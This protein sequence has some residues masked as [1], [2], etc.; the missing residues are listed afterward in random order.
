MHP[1]ALLQ[2]PG[3]QSFIIGAYSSSAGG[4]CVCC[5]RRMM[6]VYIAL[7]DTASCAA[8]AGLKTP[9]L[10]RPVLEYINVGQSGSKTCICPTGW[11]GTPARQPGNV[12]VVPTS[13]RLQRRCIV[14]LSCSST[15]RC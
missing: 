10:A 4:V 7:F 5:T 3:S 11:I 9:R 8:A 6:I 14:L 15:G 13:Y 1:A 2:L 12:S